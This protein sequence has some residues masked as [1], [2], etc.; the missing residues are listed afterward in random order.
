MTKN[1]KLIF[2]T[3]LFFNL[4]LLSVFV[5]FRYLD[6]DE[7]IYLTAAALVQEGKLPYLDFFYPQMPLLPFLYSFIANLGMNSLFLG[8]ILSAFFNFILGLFLFL[9]TKR[10]FNK[11][12]L[13]LTLFFLFS[14]NGFLLTW[15][16]V[17]KTYSLSTLFCFFSFIFLNFAFAKNEGKKLYFL[18]SGLFLGSAFS[19]RLIFLPLFFLAILLIFTLSQELLKKKIAYV[20]L[21]SCGFVISSGLIIYFL[22]S[23]PFNF[24]FENFTYHRLW[25]ENVV[26]TKPN[27][28]IS[29]LKFSLFPQNLILILLSIF[30]LILILKKKE[31]LNF[32]VLFSFIFAL[33]I[34]VSYLFVRPPQPQYYVQALP[35]LIFASAPALAYLFL[36]MKKNILKISAWLLGIIY[37]AS[38]IPILLIFVSAIREKDKVFQISEV[39]KVVTLIQKN[40]NEND[41]VLSSW[42]GYVVL[43]QR[44][45]IEG[46]E[47]V[48]YEVIKFL[49]PEEVEKLK[50]LSFEN[51]KERIEKKEIPLIVGKEGILD[52]LTNIISENYQPI[53][54]VNSIILYKP[55]E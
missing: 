24:T 48:G 4:I 1:E 28:L 16:S 19:T 53:D 15:H 7:G 52:P 8:R 55:K 6:A 29:F 14:F 54:S 5:S 46:A 35:F 40:S 42:P 38:L 39:K 23:S 22:F 45:P 13:A 37:I 47:T 49:K 51:L 36:K 11:T 31:N 18:L 41:E 32:P 44:K 10:L 21:L 27:V 33:I 17:I 3:L 26:Q 50:L 12:S 25:G 43:A 9:F 34:I 30:S 20:L 2:F